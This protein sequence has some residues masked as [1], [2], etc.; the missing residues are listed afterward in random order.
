MLPSYQLELNHIE[1]YASISIHMLLQQ[2]YQL[3]VS[4]IGT[5]QLYQHKVCHE[6]DFLQP[7][8]QF[9]HICNIPAIPPPSPSSPFLP[10][11]PSHLP[12]SAPSSPPHRIMVTGRWQSSLLTLLPR[13]YHVLLLFHI[14]TLKNA[15]LS[16]LVCS[17]S[18]T[19]HG[20]PKKMYSSQSSVTFVV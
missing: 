19:N 5:Y 17:H 7:P 1:I 6:V 14:L 15:P 11:P 10:P 18:T 9:R 20:W 3:Q 13:P 12:H 4:L 2:L 8:Q 16:F